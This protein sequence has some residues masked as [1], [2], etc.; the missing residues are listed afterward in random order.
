M[1]ECGQISSENVREL[2]TVIAERA[3]IERQHFTK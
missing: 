3:G 1:T 2:Q